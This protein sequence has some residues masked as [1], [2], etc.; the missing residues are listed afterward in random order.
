MCSIRFH[1]WQC[2]CCCFLCRIDIEYHQTNIWYSKYHTRGSH[3]GMVF[4]EA[5]AIQNGMVRRIK[6]QNQQKKGTKYHFHYSYSKCMPTISLPHVL[7][8]FFPSLWP[9]SIRYNI[10]ESERILPMCV[11]VQILISSYQ[12]MM[13]FSFFFSSSS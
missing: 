13:M 8:S 9:N 6:V 12:K 10:T 3:F 4:S 2:C 1:L 11:C 7:F 5:I